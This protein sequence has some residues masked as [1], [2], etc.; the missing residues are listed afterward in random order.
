MTAVLRPYKS[1]LSPTDLS[2]QPGAHGNVLSLLSPKTRLRLDH[3]GHNYEFSVTALP[4]NE[5]V[6]PRFSSWG[7]GWSQTF[8]T[9]GGQPASPLRMP[10]AQGRRAGPTPERARKRTR[11]GIAQRRGDI[12]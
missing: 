2:I 1:D 11:L 8:L 6:R 12:G 10:P 3:F 5:D 7:L 4:D 9:S